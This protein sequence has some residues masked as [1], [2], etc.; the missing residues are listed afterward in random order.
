[1]ETTV[2]G[3]ARVR[4][5][6]PTGYFYFYM[7]ASCVA[8]AFLGFAPTYWMPVVQGTFRA[9]PIVHIHGLTFFAWTLFFAFQTWLAASGRLARHRAVGLIG[10]SFATLV[11]VLGTLVAINMMRNAAA[12]GQAEAGF[13][14]ALVPLSGILL[15]AV[16]VAFA[17]GNVRRPEWHKR[18]MLVATISL[19][20]AAIARWFFVFLA[21]AG[22]P[23]PP[24]V[25]ATF[26]P[27]V[28]TVGLLL[29]GIAYDWRLRGRVH[30]AYLVGTGAYIAL[31][32]VELPLSATPAWHTVA[33]GVLAL[34][35]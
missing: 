13:A 11:T 6:S 2:S 30:P 4:A 5:E 22:P 35:G 27:A 9:N 3:R 7:A 21:P 26:Q 18:L 12:I 16:L 14:F 15:F 24:L 33:R 19:L 25:E 32:L 10:I 20:E 17:I 23:G 34:A 28:V 31:K 1:M 29:V 8:V